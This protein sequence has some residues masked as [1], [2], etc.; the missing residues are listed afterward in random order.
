MSE[1]DIKKLMDSIY[2]AGKAGS[3][4]DLAMQ[5]IGRATDAIKT[6]ALTLKGINFA[7]WA[8]ANA[9]LGTLFSVFKGNGAE[10]FA[11]GNKLTESLLSSD[12]AF[13]K[14]YTG[15]GNELPRM[16]EELA[17][18]F[19][20]PE[21]AFEISKKDPFAFVRAFLKNLKEN[22][23]SAPILL[24]RIRQQMPELYPGM[25]ELSSNG[26]KALEIINKLD[27]AR[28]ESAQKEATKQLT[29]KERGPEDII[30]YMGQQMEDFLLTS[31]RA[32]MAVREITGTMGG[33]FTW[34]KK[35]RAEE[36]ASGGKKGFG[37]DVLDFFGRIQQLGPAGLFGDAT[38]GR[39]ER[40]G[41]DYIRLLLRRG[42]I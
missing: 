33:W 4:G 23:S 42:S 27:K 25:E 28:H 17:L 31:D 35:V 10:G 36:K 26:E 3:Y 38:V 29:S 11:A 19:R 41:D 15:L 18:F 24:E 14:L 37:S 7:E 6:S 8:K 5:N 22:A 2:S 40:I 32:N 1:E 30:T 13:Q 9:Q 21:K 16:T 34:M 39:D 20:Q 12:A